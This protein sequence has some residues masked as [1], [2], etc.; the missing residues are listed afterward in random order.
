MYFI[1]QSTST[2]K[3]LK[4]MG[5][6]SNKAISQACAFRSPFSG[7]GER[8]RDVSTSTLCVPQINQIP[9]APFHTTDVSLGNKSE[10][11]TALLIRDGPPLA[12]QPPPHSVRAAV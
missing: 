12:Y 1:V 4:G 2:S 10:A 8:Y 11:C 7:I 6:C 3:W 9:V 5:R